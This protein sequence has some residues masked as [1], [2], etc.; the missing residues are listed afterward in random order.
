MAI[1]EG[2]NRNWEKSKK[3]ERINK[4][5]KNQKKKQQENKQQTTK[6]ATQC[7]CKQIFV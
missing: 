3:K 5:I 6:S 2:K 4:Q 7:K 1:Q